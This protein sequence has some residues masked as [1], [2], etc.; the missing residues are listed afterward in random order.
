MF[1]RGL[2]T[3]R[4]SPVVLGVLFSMAV[5]GLSADTGYAQKPRSKPLPRG[6]KPSGETE[7]KP[8]KAKPRRAKPT[9]GRSGKEKPGRDKPTQG[10]PT[11]GKEKDGNKPEIEIPPD[12]QKKIDELME[13]EGMQGVEPADEPS[14][15]P[16]L[17]GKRK[18]SRPKGK[19]AV[20]EPEDEEQEEKPRPEKPRQDRDTVSDEGD[21]KGRDEEPG[22]AEDEG[23]GKGT[24]GD[25]EKDRDKGAEPPPAG[26]TTP[27]DIPPSDAPDDVNVPP[28]QRMYEFSIKDGTYE[29][30][31]AGVARQTGLGILG[32]APKDGKVTFVTEEILTFDEMLGR[33]KMLL[34]NYKPHEPYWLLR[35]QT[36]LEVIRINDL[37]RLLD[38]RQMFGSVEEFRAAG[39]SDDELAL[40]IYSP[41]SG[42]VADLEVVRDFMPD[43]VRV[44][45][46]EEQNAVTVFALVSDID[47]Y[48][49]LVEFFKG[50]RHDPRITE[51]IATKH[52]LP[53]EAWALLQ[54][55]MGVAQEES[56]PRKG[57]PRDRS[58][59]GTMTAHEA[60]IVPLDAQGVLLVRAMQDDIDEIKALLPYIDLAG[61]TDCKPVVIGLQYADA[62]QIA[63]T[64][65]QILEA[66]SGAKGGSESSV[67][68]TGKKK[69][70]G[71]G[72]RGTPAAVTTKNVTLLPHPA[73]NALIV[74]A[75]P[76]DVAEVRRLV[77][78]L[79]KKGDEGPIRIAIEHINPTELVA[80]LT[81]MILGPGGDRGAK[82]V[83]F[84]LVPDPSGNA[85]WFTGTSDDLTRTREIIK[86]V[87]VPGAV[88][89]LHVIKLENQMPSFVA[90]ILEEYDG[91]A[92]SRAS[93]AR[94]KGGK[95]KGKAGRG[96]P[97]GRFTPDDET[98]RLFVLCTDEDWD[99]YLPVIE[100]L[101]E[102][103][104]PDEPAFVLIPV[105]HIS[106]EEAIVKLTS[107]LSG[108]GDDKRKGS[109]GIRFEPS[110]GAVVVVRATAEEIEQM[111]EVLSV[112]DTP[113]VEIITKWFEIQ[114]A[115]PSN[116]MTAIQTLVGD[117]PG[118]AVPKPKRRKGAAPGGVTSRQLTVVPMG[119][120]LIVKAT[121]EDMERI[122]TLIAEFDVEEGKTE[123]RVY[124][125]FSPGTDVTQLGAKLTT[126]L[127][128]GAPGGKPR[129]GRPEVGARAPQIVP[130][131]EAGKLLVIAQPE[132][133]PEIEE[134][135][136]ILRSEAGMEVYE[137]EFVKLEYAE[138]D[139]VV[140]LVAP[141]LQVQVRELER[142]GE[143]KGAPGPAR[144]PGKGK[145]PVARAASAGGWFHLESDARNDRIVIAAPR[146]VID[147]AKKL[148]AEFDM[149]QDDVTLR[150]YEDFAPGANM[151]QVAAMLE[152]LL[153]GGQ[154][155]PRG[156]KKTLEAKS[157]GPRI[158][159]QSDAGKL[160]VIAEAAMFP[161]I[162]EKLEIVRA[163]ITITEPYETAFVDVQYAEPAEIVE[164][165]QPLLSVRV[166]ELVRIGRLRG[167]P[168]P[169]APAGK[170]KRGGGARAP[171]AGGDW[172]HLEADPRNRRIVVAAPRV[173]I[174]E[175]ATLISQFDLPGGATAL[176]V[177][178]GFPPGSDVTKIA[179][180]LR[181][182]LSGGEVKQRRGG[183]KTEQP[184]TVGGPQIVPQ[185]ELGK[186]IVV[187]D[188]ATHTE[189]EGLIELFRGGLERPVILTA[190]VELEYADPNSVVGLIDP[191]LSM[192]VRELLA[193][194][195]LN[196][197]PEPVTAPAG[198]GKG[199][200]RGAT[201]RGGGTWYHLDAD[202][203]NSRV[204]IAA[205]QI[206][207]DEA[208]RLIGA[209]DLVDEEHERVVKT[210]TLENATA[211]AMVK[212]IREMMGAP[213]RARGAATKKGG[214]VPEAVA[215]SEFYIA[216]A[217]GGRAVVLRGVQEVIDLA[218]EWI[219]ELDGISVGGR[220]VKIFVIEHFP[221]KRLVDLIMATVDTP[222]AGG[223]PGAGKRP[224]PRGGKA[225]EEEED[226]AWV[227]EI[228]RTGAEMYVHADL[229]AGTMLVSTTPTKMAEIESL[230]EEM[231]VDTVADLVEAARVP[232]LIYELKYA[233]PFDAAFELDMV[234]EAF[235]E[236]DE[237]PQVGSGLWGDYL[238]V[239]YPDESR[240]P[241]IEELIVKYVD[242][243]GEDYGKTA[244]IVVVPPEGWTAERLAR[245]LELNNPDVEFSTSDISPR[246][247]KTYGVEQVR[248]SGAGG[249]P[250]VMPTALQAA[251]DALMADAVAQLGGEEEDPPEGKSGPTE[252]DDPLVRAA[253]A[254]L[255]EKE[256]SSPPAAESDDAGEEGQPFTE[257][258]Q[259]KKSVTAK[260]DSEGR[261]VI[262]ESDPDL[263]ED[264]EEQLEKL[265]E[266]EKKV[267]PPPDI[268]IY[269][270]RYIDVHT[271]TE[272]I[273]EMFNATQQQRQQVTA[274]ARRAAQQQARQQRQ[275]QQQQQQEQGRQ[276][277]QQG[278]PPRGQRGQ[279]QPP[280]VP[281]LPPTSVRIYP[282]PRDRTLILRADSSQFPALLELIATI[283][284][285]Q[286]IESTF[287][288]FRLERLNA[289][290]T[291]EV[292]KEMLGL[293][294]VSSR[295]QPR[296]GPSGQ[297]RGSTRGSRSTTSTGGHLPETIMQ[298]VVSGTGALGVDAKDIKI[299][300]NEE[301][302]TI[303]VMA[304]E[305]A[306]DYV[307]ALIERL[308][309]YELP[310]RIWK[311]YELAFAKAE[312]VAEYLASYFAEESP[313]TGS[314]RGGRS[315]KGSKATTS[316]MKLDA[317]TFVPYTRLN[318]LSVQATAEDM[319][320]VD[321]IIEQLDVET[322]I[323]VEFKVYVLQYADA[324]KVH[325]Q[326]KALLVDY[327]RQL[328]RDAGDKIQPFS[329]EV[330]EKANALMVLGDA[331]V[332]AFLEDNLAKVDIP[333]NARA[334]P[335][336]LA[337]TLKNASA[338]EAAQAINRLW[339]AKNV[340]ASETPPQ[341]EAARATNTLI[342]RGTQ[343]Q[344]D[345]IKE[346]FI[347]PL[348]EST[349]ARETFVY[350]LDVADAESLARTLQEAYRGRGG[351]GGGRGEQAVVIA[352]DVSTNSL[353]ITATQ[354]EMREIE[355][356]IEPLDSDATMLGEEVRVVTLLYSDANEVKE[357]V[358]EYLRR[359]GAGGGRGGRGAND[360]AGDVRLSVLVQTNAVIVSGETE[361]VDHIETLIR[362][363]D[364]AGE[365]G[366]VPQ[367]IPLK[368]ANVGNILPSLEEMFEEA[369]GGGRRNQPA[370]TLVANDMLN[371][372]IVR[373]APTDVAAIEAIVAQLDVPSAAEQL[374]YRV[375]DV[376]PGINVIS[377][378]ELIQEAVN[379]GAQAQAPSGRRGGQVPSISV[380]PD[381][382]TN[383]ITISGSPRLF[384]Q[385]EQLA[386]EYIAKRPG[387]GMGM[388][389][390]PLT[391]VP[392]DD[393]IRLIEQLKGD[394][395]SS[396]VRSSRGGSSRGRR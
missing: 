359:P 87:D 130:H 146:K 109:A 38:R 189:I 114:F 353:V 183:K 340:P 394:T 336:S 386:N 272:I 151:D 225:M 132:K 72:S 187:A 310:E 276:P 352:A 334:L 226:V 181:V 192:F 107:L 320:E 126:L 25:K 251:V 196:G 236:G 304:P 49:G 377:L 313:Q 47:K 204:V 172:F 105:E 78:E 168:E 333:A 358:T 318:L 328:G 88:V 396:R 231:D 157:A 244:K 104:D 207:I 221:I 366:S 50:E 84:Q 250:C 305:A 217:P 22:K 91:A 252:S 274:A 278:Q 161:E 117:Q 143:L 123:L 165:V 155:T 348:E 39:L 321:G 346:Q 287:R 254:L 243:P 391:S 163:G 52:I 218:T 182:L 234:L 131:P 85:V 162:E 216:E 82:N 281:T 20:D 119:N 341:A 51:K 259:P 263:I 17:G 245:W 223:K 212:T 220:I 179:D 98:G 62:E 205:P 290:E 385:A 23:R 69:K 76:E 256:S 139:D 292:L 188:E 195:A 202:L 160:I 9:T 15:D 317:P 343:D 257:E 275:R 382:R 203:R 46:L 70:R 279:Q 59:L 219:E 149:P 166:R 11:G 246:R 371:A 316:T 224:R 136:E 293:D 116:I 8:G 209:F 164:I 61:P 89:S 326:M 48:L 5:Y 288:T 370:P 295:A 255:D 247:G 241:E 133:F 121:A 197:T 319:A 93:S 193:T 299:S 37:Y 31:L 384:A 350:Q 108:V 145:K 201:A 286:P 66:T 140:N 122:E 264:I 258:A 71:R 215:A 294:Q 190:F 235:W 331:V 229:I 90:G 86:T 30:L 335:A 198:K 392:A 332:F 242:K 178:D 339:G 349:L 13:Q 311:S 118:A 111:R 34:F 80:T 337:V 291:V 374:N 174:D 277:G 36:H 270:L 152:T 67:R 176:R 63:A 112:F 351:G 18:M 289:A 92:G 40:V 73:V 74:I 327:M 81:Q 115:D 60:S 68:I 284:Q 147:E 141:L 180:T 239:E 355:A 266:D 99:R 363:M 230:V 361:R 227:T 158:I 7:N 33:V 184:V 194:G 95:K 307:G 156:G 200:G 14:A 4:Y 1:A 58:A 269:R 379:E 94:P 268:R 388:T 3:W 393:V 228:T 357:S 296:R 169:V 129:K 373:G 211:S 54:T 185:P 26:P 29:H 376:P 21:K 300:S 167:A 362:Q 134:Y 389:I 323:G 237:L 103:V 77:A 330:D 128:G 347:D 267:S 83:P 97:A 199:K 285:P 191:L 64:I 354:E 144:L 280:Q 28:E 56:K 222:T 271:A 298:D 45:P 240:F 301:A 106:P 282:S 41:E 124:E 338:Q 113:P 27:I 383:T 154:P 24:R 315:R 308:D 110:D 16:K 6:T 314:S 324:K 138:P 309:G 302:N 356:L 265:E 306:L 44:T 43:Y 214:K 367:I 261:I 120:R 213:G 32:D 232:K 2:S 153:A 238:I 303:L 159:P 233:D 175:A 375:V 273:N 135:L 380:I 342:I 173:V 387:K 142:A 381:S 100:Q 101:E 390:I 253:L 10:K 322:G 364:E 148:I 369:R 365:K 79:D 65:M 260:Y 360:L 283:D 19:P 297:Q 35:K 262:L 249:S 177:Y 206:I 208:T 248:P 170:A 345:E 137:R 344:I 127:S 312:E 75:D 55:L 210:I 186:I 150:V 325:E 42:S 329:V 171:R 372:L 57:R 368:Y 395:S 96:A 125:G 378:A 12:I 53:S 102:Q